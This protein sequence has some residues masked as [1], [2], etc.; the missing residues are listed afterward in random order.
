MLNH[1]SVNLYQT[2]STNDLH[3]SINTFSGLSKIL[4]K[5]GILFY[6]T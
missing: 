4:K 5:N 3:K 2:I 1:V 6:F